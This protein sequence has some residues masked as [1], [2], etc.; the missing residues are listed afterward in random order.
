MKRIHHMFR[1]KEEIEN[2]TPDVWN[3]IEGKI[4]QRIVTNLLKDLDGLPSPEGRLLGEIRDRV[5]QHI[6]NKG[7]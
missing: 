5:K 1:L 4:T 6:L 3:E 2:S 7:A